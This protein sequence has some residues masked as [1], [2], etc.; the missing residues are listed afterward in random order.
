MSSAEQPERLRPGRRP[1]VEDIETLLAASTPHFAL[2]LRERIAR[3]IRDLPPDDPAWIAG[4]RAKAALELLAFTG[5]QRG[6]PT[7][8]DLPPLKSV[9][10]PPPAIARTAAIQRRAAPARAPVPAR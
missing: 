1:T 2:Q 4:V 6:G 3:L 9:G 8:P 7:P 5:E 10:P